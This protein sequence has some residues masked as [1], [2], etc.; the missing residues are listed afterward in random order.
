[1]SIRKKNMKVPKSVPLSYFQQFLQGNVNVLIIDTDK[2]L[3]TKIVFILCMS[4]SSLSWTC[5]CI[6]EM[7]DIIMNNENY[8]WFCFLSI[9]IVDVNNFMNKAIDVMF[10]F[11]HE[12]ICMLG[13]TVAG[14]HEFWG[15]NLSSEFNLLNKCN[16]TFKWKNEM[17]TCR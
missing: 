12:V 1:M 16:F 15:Q 4:M 2:F 17:H 5:L 6:F 14:C 8:L 3:T 9:K 13:N 10:L 7:I 11:S